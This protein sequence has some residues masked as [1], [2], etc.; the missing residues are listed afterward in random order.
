[1][2]ISE[3]VAHLEAIRAELGDL[4]VEAYAYGDITTYPV[5]VPEVSQERG[6]RSFVLVSGG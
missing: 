6:G 3:V 2:L 5:E 1:M 4:E